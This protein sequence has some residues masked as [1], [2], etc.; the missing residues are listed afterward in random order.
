LLE[1]E[2]FTVIDFASGA[3]FLRS[4]RPNTHSCLLL[5]VHMPDM[6][7]ID[8][9]D[10][11]RSDKFDI[12]VILMTGCSSAAIETAAARAGVALVE[13]PFRGRELFDAIKKNLRGNSIL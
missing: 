3:E 5:D 8:L 12:S 4:A 13:K 2:G 11:M 7:G 1:L 6:S 10:Q 9:L